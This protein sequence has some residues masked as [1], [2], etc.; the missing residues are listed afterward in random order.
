MRCD[1]AI[2]SGGWYSKNILKERGDEMKRRTEGWLTRPWVVCLL[3]GTC[4][5][6]W[7]SAMPVIKQGYT[8][9][10]IPA[11]D[12]AAKILFAGLRFAV[13]GGLVILFSSLSA[14][15]FL[16]P[17][18]KSLPYVFKLAMVQTVLQYVFLYVG[19]ANTAGVRS[20][21]LNGCSS[22]FAILLACFLLRTE[23]FTRAKLLGCV[24]GPAG[25]ILMNL[26][27]S[28]GGEGASLLGD[29]CILLAALSYALSSALV[30]V[31][32]RYENPVILS[33]WQFLVGGIVMSLLSLALGGRLHGTT[34]EGLALFLY[35]AALSAVAYSLWG[36]LLKRN[37]V[38]SVTIYG[39]MT[40][41]FGV[42]LSGLLLGEQAMD[43]KTLGAMLLV[44]GSIF[45]V[46]Y[47]EYHP[48]SIKHDLTGG[49]ER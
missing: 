23:R 18:S 42:L 15:K 27:G 9:W 5:L 41:L 13:A 30:K 19:L 33:G 8:L 1:N 31:Y 38:S 37:P 6:L 2:H 3:A 46:N 44:C 34:G 21:I 29:A 43:A 16:L 40:P 35:L 14:R 7:G 26:G 39:F 49:N 25:V 10:N 4:C 17:K 12:Y 45:V 32:A 48:Q 24:L 11:G 36:T 47:A 22:C 28:S 20:S